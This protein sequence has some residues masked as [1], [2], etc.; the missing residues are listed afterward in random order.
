HQILDAGVE[1]DGNIDRSHLRFTALVEYLE[2]DVVV[3]DALEIARVVVLDMD[4]PEDAFHAGV[5][6]YRGSFERLFRVSD[7][8]PCRINRLSRQSRDG[9]E[10]ESD[11]QKKSHG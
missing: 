8:K 1:G 4:A 6:L 5:W 9:K 2:A 3:I 10:R 7:G 11:R